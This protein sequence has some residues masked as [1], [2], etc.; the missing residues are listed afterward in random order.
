MK[1]FSQLNMCIAEESKKTRERL[2]EI[3]SDPAEQIKYV[4]S[5][6]QT[7]QDCNPII[8]KEHRRDFAKGIP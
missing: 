4:S 7:G 2:A 5:I 8:A 6:K 3:S 1:F